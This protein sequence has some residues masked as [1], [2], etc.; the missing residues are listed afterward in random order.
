M[1]EVLVDRKVPVSRFPEFEGEWTRKK[2]NVV[3]DIY[4]GTHQTMVNPV[5]RT[6]NG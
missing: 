3:A 4:D 5:V 2:F 1:E 6:G